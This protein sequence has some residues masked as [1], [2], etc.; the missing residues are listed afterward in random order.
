MKRRQRTSDLFWHRQ[1]LRAFLSPVGCA[2]LLLFL[3]FIFNN[4]SASVSASYQS[5]VVHTALRLA[6]DTSSNA[7]IVLVIDNTN[8]IK[9]HDPTGARFWAAQMFV[10]QVQ[11]GNRIGVERIT[12][13]DKS[14][15]VKVLNLTTIQNGND[16]HTIKQMLTQSFFGPIDPGPTAYFVPAL[17][18]ATQMLLSTQD[19]H[20]KYVIVM[21]D[22]LAQTGDQEPC[23]SAPDQRHQWFCEIPI[24]ESHNISVIL[25]SFTTPG[26]EA[27]LQP[28]R[29]Y[30]EQHG[31]IVLQVG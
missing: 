6:A 10:D 15:P 30:L 17:Q 7:D 11:P 8:E 16:R 28:T 20:R 5:T 21:T 29:H 13:S 23:S 19:N 4:G 22:S 3:S 14:S 25:F 26:R 9:S 12:S 31:A 27:E 1:S 24:V 18:T 2:S